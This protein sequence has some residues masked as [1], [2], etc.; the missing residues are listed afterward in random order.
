[1]SLFHRYDWMFL[2]FV[3]AILTRCSYQLADMA[4]SH[5]PTEA[6]AVGLPFQVSQALGS[7]VVATDDVVQSGIQTM[8]NYML[9]ILLASILIL[10]MLLIMILRSKAIAQYITERISHVN[11]MMIGLL[12]AVLLLGARVIFGFAVGMKSQGISSDATSHINLIILLLLPVIYKTLHPAY[13][14]TFTTYNLLG[15]VL[16][17]AGAFFLVEDDQHWIQFNN[18]Q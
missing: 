6:V 1:M 4:H 3:G 13:P 11:F 10:P 7:N 16:I 15:I 18:D 5:V 14:H 9:T 2:V 12:A 17:I 8:I